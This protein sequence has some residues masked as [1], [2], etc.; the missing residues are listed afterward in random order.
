MTLAVVTAPFRALPTTR[1]RHRD[2]MLG[3]DL[4]GAIAAT[5]KGLSPDRAQREAVAACQYLLDA[6]EWAVADGC[7]SARTSD[8]AM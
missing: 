2:V 6:G 4:A 7:D 8:E 3:S 1:Q 5:M